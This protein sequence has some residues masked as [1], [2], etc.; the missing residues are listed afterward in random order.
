MLGSVN[1]RLTDDVVFAS[2]K[3]GLFQLVAVLDTPEALDGT[4]EEL[5]SAKELLS[6][7]IRV[8]EATY[9]ITQPHQMIIEVPDRQSTRE[10]VVRVLSLDEFTPHM[11]GNY[12]ELKG[13]DSEL[14]R[15]EISG[16]Y[17]ILR[18]DRFMF[19]EC[20]GIGELVEASK[21]LG[22]TLSGVENIRSRLW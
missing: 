1:P 15:R 13:Y 8:D 9:I 14:L 11:L 19:A 4:M 6:D 7:E 10:N 2:S 22:E 16:K 12:P 18:P 3:T 17:V 20:V 21:R 5:E